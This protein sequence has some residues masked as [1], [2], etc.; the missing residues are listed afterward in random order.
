MSATKT[1]A[2]INWFLRLK[3]K[4]PDG[5]H[6]IS[7]LLQCIALFDTLTFEE[8]QTLSVMTE[9]PIAGDE[10]LVMRAALAIREASKTSRGARISLVKNIPIAAGLGGGSSDAAA[11]LRGL[12]SLWDAGLSD[13]ELHAAALGLGSDVPFFLSGPAAL[14]RGRGELISPVVMS[15]AYS[16]VLLNPGLR[17]SAGWAYA[18]ARSFSGEDKGI[19]DSLVRALNEGDFDVL[20]G[21]AV[22]DLEEP[23]A[24]R[25]P[26]VS[27]LK[28]RLYEEG[29]L[30]AA[31]SGSGPTVFGAFEDRLR[32][33]EARRAIRAAWSTVAHTVTVAAE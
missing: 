10:N 17:V 18:E 20:R 28:R 9:A 4:R 13:R 14:V 6:D 2:K 16:V 26:E 23:V 22:N 29:A 19:E 11:T 1:P 27:E 5:Y 3:G 12:N 30:F 25:H 15:R 33:E 31:M 21:A 24:A 32:A 7:S 8:A